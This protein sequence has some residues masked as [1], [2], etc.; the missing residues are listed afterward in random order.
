MPAV[1][2]VQFAAAAVISYLGLLAGFFLASL[3]REE[4]PTA[5]RYFQLLQRLVVLAA[6]AVAMEYFS[7]SIFVKVAVY[8]LL[9]LLLAVSIRTS[10]YYAVFGVV[11]FF[12][13]ASQNALL[14]LSSLVFLFGLLSG[15]IYFERNVKKKADFASKAAEMLMNNSFY[16][17]I[18][19]VLYAFSVYV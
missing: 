8:L 6:A 19:V 7:V 1:T 10:F 16:P 4:L 9:L 3:T 13:S 2:L 17:V 15:S 12:V 5:K 11:V 14:V 18:A